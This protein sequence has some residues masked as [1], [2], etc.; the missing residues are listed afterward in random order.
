MLELLSQLLSLIQ[1]VLVTPLLWLFPIKWVVVDP[2]WSAVRYTCG[3]PSGML[4]PGVH[5][6]TCTQLLVK[7]HICTRV[8]P[9]DP[10]STLTKDGVP[11]R[12]DAVITYGISNLSSFFASAE[13]PDEHLAAVAEAA[14]RTALSSRT[15]LAIVSDSSTIEAEIRK[16]VAESVSGCGIRIKKARFQNIEQLPDY[17][18]MMEKIL[19]VIDV[20]PPEESS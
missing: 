3:K 8:A 11:L 14:V 17:V 10:V 4:K 2:G 7:K 16:Q 5:F 6:G 13:D 20:L 18:R 9:T 15:F 19:P 12:S 1:D